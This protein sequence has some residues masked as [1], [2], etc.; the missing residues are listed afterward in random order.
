MEQV[1]VKP[2]YNDDPMVGRACALDVETTGVDA[3]RDRV[4]SFGWVEMQEGKITDNTIEWFFNPGS[5]DI[6]PDALAVHGITI[7]FLRDKPPIKAYLPKII[8]LV[9]DAVVCG[10][11]VKF[12]IDMI[13]AELSRHRYPMLDQYMRGRFD[14]MLAS[15]ERSPGKAAHLDGVCDRLGVS[16]AHRNK[17]GALTDA[18]LC[19]Q[20]AVVMHREQRSLLDMFSTREDTPAPAEG[21]E[22]PLS[23]ILVVQATAD[24]L[25]EHDAYLA[26]LM[27]NGTTPVWPAREE[28]ELAARPFA[29]DGD[30]G[31][32]HAFGMAAV[33]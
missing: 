22:Q 8:E 5:V 26:D 27:E 29:D 18:L 4:I 16:R 13:N 33:A 25:A 19:A 12:D 3:K 9:I 20:V 7:E 1:I 15:R 10:H 30:A 6:H 24:E 32:D 11:N 21:G 2:K 17:H 14:T 23:A 28:E 31:P